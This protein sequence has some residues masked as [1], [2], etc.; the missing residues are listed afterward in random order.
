MIIIGE[1]L[2]SSRPAVR[3]AFVK[4]DASYLTEQAR[5]Q[6]LAGASFLDVNA[7]ALLEVEAE[8]LRWAVPL[9]QKAAG[10]PLSID[11]PDPTAMEAALGAY[12]G[13]ALLNSLTGEK[14][15]TEQCLPLIK[16]YHPRVIVLC[17]DDRGAATTPVRALAIARRITGLLLRQGLKCEDIFVD[18]LVHSAAADRDAAVRVLA[19]LRMIKKRLP[20]IRTVAGLSNISFGLPHRRIVNRA[21]LVMAL[22]AGLDAA[23]CD[24]LDKDLRMALAAG[25][26]LLGRKQD[27]RVDSLCLS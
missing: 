23:I 8:V 24:P 4:R 13:R 3:D 22:E 9:L 20:G 17:L 18:P 6:A 26:A 2:N 11:S 12:R 1:R 21:F 27:W 25:E 15:K 14:T 16:R 19:S 10:I 7:A 5:L